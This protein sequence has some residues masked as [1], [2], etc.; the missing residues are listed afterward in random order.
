MNKLKPIQTAAT[1][2]LTD[3]SKF[4]YALSLLCL[5]TGLLL[6]PESA[7]RF[8]WLYKALAPQCVHEEILSTYRPVRP[9]RCAD[10]NDL[11]ILHSFPKSGDLN[12]VNRKNY[13]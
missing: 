3:I 1:S 6:T 7:Q 12:G 8:Y 11:V 13:Q 9:L 2:I 4:E 10:H 5:Y